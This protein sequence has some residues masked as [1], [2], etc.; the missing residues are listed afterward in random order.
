MGWFSLK[1]AFKQSPPK[2]LAGEIQ[3]ALRLRYLGDHSLLSCTILLIIVGL[4]F[5]LLAFSVPFKFV[6]FVC[7]SHFPLILKTPIKGWMDGWM[8]RW[9][10]RWIDGWM[11]GWMDGW[12]RG[13]MDRWMDG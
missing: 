7:P 3:L 9:M 13:W 8:N 5:K 10:D 4:I 1:F 2:S 11:D 12:V 6:L